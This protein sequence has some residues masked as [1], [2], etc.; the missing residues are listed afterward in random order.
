MSK[1][2]NTDEQFAA[3]RNGVFNKTGLKVAADDPVVQLIKA[4]Q[5][6]IDESYAV[7]IK[8]LESKSLDIIN[9]IDTHNKNALEGLT[10]QLSS[11]S[12]L[13]IRVESMLNEQQSQAIKPQLLLY[14]ML[15]TAAFSVAISY[16]ITLVF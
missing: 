14:Y 12:D 2:E 13:F 16:L 5:D 15:G 6:F 1:Q 10:A 9:S 4:Q 8:E 7:A 3:I 11:L